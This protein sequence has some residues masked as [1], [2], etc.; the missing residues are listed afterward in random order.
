MD[1]YSYTNITHI[2]FE[3]SLF[4]LVKRKKATRLKGDLKWL[5]F[6]FF[7]SSTRFMAGV[8]TAVIQIYTFRGV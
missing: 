2:F 4:L 5:M 3:F 6:R 1:T 8:T 7:R